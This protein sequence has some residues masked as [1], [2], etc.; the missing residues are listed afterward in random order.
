M[1]AVLEK[2]HAIHYI[3]VCTKV[4]SKFLNLALPLSMF[5]VTNA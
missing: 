4:D 3:Y 1:E 5:L 2:F